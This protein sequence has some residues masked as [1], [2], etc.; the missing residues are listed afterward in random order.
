MSNNPWQ[1]FPSNDPAKRWNIVI[2]QQKETT[3][4]GGARISHG[5][6]VPFWLRT[7]ASVYEEK[8]LTDQTRPTDGRSCRLE[9]SC[10]GTWA[11][12]L[13]REWLQKEDSCATELS[14]PCRRLT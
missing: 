10:G 9:Y 1:W 5:N 4:P 7:S 2:R 6:Q 8:T 14:S 11:S 13:N 3:G 12:G